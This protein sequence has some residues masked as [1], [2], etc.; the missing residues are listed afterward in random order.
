MPS[1]IAG[2]DGLE[3]LAAV[4]DLLAQ[5]KSGQYYVGNQYKSVGR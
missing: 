1:C 5:R 2:F 4:R 3:I